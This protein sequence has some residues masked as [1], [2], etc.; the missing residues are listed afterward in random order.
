MSPSCTRRYRV[1]PLV[2]GSKVSSRKLT[3]LFPEAVKS[4]YDLSSNGYVPGPLSV[5]ITGTSVSGIKI[6][7]RTLLRPRSRSGWVDVRLRLDGRVSG[8]S[9]V[10]VGTGVSVCT[11]V[12]KV[13][14]WGSFGTLNRDWGDTVSNSLGESL[15]T[16]RK[17]RLIYLRRG[18]CVDYYLGGKCLELHLGVGEGSGY[19]ILRS[20]SN[21]ETPWFILCSDDLRDHFPSTWFLGWDL[22]IRWYTRPTL[23]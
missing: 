5:V 8:R 13:D 3:C 11:S 9:F 20:R 1:D 2:T 22:G 6:K 16:R 10:W 17:G 21:R 7:S 23:G 12:T 15:G 4:R 18:W 19:V 14:I